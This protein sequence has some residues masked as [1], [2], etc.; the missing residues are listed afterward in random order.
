MGKKKAS[1]K[2]Y[3]SNGE[4]PN[5]N[6]K[7]LNAM[8]KA[9]RA[10]MAANMESIQAKIA[11]RDMAFSKKGS[12]ARIIQDKLIERDSVDQRAFELY[13]KF[14]SKGCTWA[15]AVQAVKTDWVAN[16]TMKYS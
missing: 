1:S 7:T 14:K 12:E 9:R 10:S 8:R 3:V 13:E 5:V 6:R 4:R 16:L 15:A 2:G 11:Y